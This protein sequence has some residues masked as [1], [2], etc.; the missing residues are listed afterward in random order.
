[1]AYDFAALRAEYHE[2]WESSHPT[3]RMRAASASAARKIQA[4]RLRYNAVEAVTGVPWWIVGI[5]HQ[6][7]CGGSWEQ[8]LHNGDSLKAR[9]WQVP[10]GRP[11]APPANGGSVYSWEESAID[12]ILYDKLDKVPEWS[13]ERICFV[14]EGYNGWGY[15]RHHPDVLSPYL[16]SGTNHYTR[17]KYVADGRWSATAVSGQPGAISI[18]FAL[19]EIEPSVSPHSDPARLVQS[20][21]STG[22]AEAVDTAALTTASD[23]AGSSRKIDTLNATQ[24]TATGLGLTVLGFSVVDLLSL[25]Q[26]ITGQI[27]AMAADHVLAIIVVL[28]FAGAGVAW[29]VKRWIVQ[30]YRSGRYVPSKAEGSS[31]VAESGPDASEADDA[32]PAAA[33]A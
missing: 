2:L 16:W 28:C 3:D 25:A 26:S 22:W 11:K 19:V 4:G 27:K 6:M 17:G 21:P 15:R 20:A 31:S 30:D 32:D 7:E 24:G 12:A 8:H 14:L 1:M 18:L 29:A 23:L 10:A 13:P 5:I 9:T 33:E